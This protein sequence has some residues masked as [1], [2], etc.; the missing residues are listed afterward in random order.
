MVPEEQQAGAILVEQAGLLKDADDLVP[1]RLL[2]G[3]GVDVRHGNPL[4]RGAP[5]ATCGEGMNV[6]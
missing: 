4:A 3:G 2:G 5:A 1:E 6:G